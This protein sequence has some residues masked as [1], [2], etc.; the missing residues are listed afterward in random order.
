MRLDFLE[1]VNF[2]ESTRT[3]LWFIMEHSKKRDRDDVPDFQFTDEE[4]QQLVAI[5]DL[6][7]REEQRQRQERK[8][9][10]T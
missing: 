7:N 5:H 10:R 4:T 2:L 1:R 6:L 8:E 9:L 3:R